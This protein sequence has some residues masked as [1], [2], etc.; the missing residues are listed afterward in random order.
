MSDVSYFFDCLKGF[1]D[2][3]IVDNDIFLGDELRTAVEFSMFSEARTAISPETNVQD[4]IAI[5]SGW[6]A[7]TFADQPL[8]SEAWIYRR[9][10]ITLDTLNGLSEAYTKSLQWLIDDGVVE[11]ATVTAVKS[12]KI[13]N[14]IEILASFV[15][16]NQQTETFKWE[17]AWEDVGNAV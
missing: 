4:S 1:A 12:S 16:P 11:T 15:K 10:K 17:F 5:L 2:I 9:R 14:T 8:G 7:D 3:Q 13:P 6:W